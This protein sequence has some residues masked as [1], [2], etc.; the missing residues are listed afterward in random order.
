MDPLHRPL[1]PFVPYMLPCPLLY[2]PAETFDMVY[3]VIGM[4]ADPHPLAPSLHCWGYNRPDHE[5][6]LLAETGQAARL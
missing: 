3:A 6:S 2:S 5:P 1:S 4:Y